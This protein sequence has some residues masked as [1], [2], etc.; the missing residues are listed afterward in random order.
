MVVKIFLCIALIIFPLQ[1]SFANDYIIKLDDYEELEFSSLTNQDYSTIDLEVKTAGKKKPNLGSLESNL[2]PIKTKLQYQPFN[3][4]AQVEAN[5]DL[6]E[7]YQFFKYNH[8]PR[9]LI[10]YTSR[11]IQKGA[12]DILHIKSKLKDGSKQIYQDFKDDYQN[13]AIE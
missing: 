10:P 8:D 9:K 13:G 11:G 6:I 1:M 5:M 4:A 12:N 2:G 7:S 3:Q